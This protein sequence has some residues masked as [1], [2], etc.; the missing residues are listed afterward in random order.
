VLRKIDRYE[1]L[2]ELGHGGMATVYRARDTK[3]D[4]LV[5]LKVMHP[6]LR[7]AKEARDRFR[8][9]AQSVARLAHPRILEIYDYSGEESEESYIAGQLLTGPTLRVWGEA[10][11]PIPAEIVACIGI[12]LAGALAAAHDKGI[13]HR[14]VKP[15]NI[16]LHEA[17]E[18][19]LTD[20]G[21]AAMVDSHSMTA[22]GQILGSPG[23]MAP[24]QI[25]GGESD[26][27]TDLFALGTVLFFLATGRLPFVGKN[28]HQILKRVIDGEHPDPLRLEP[29]MG[30][31]LRAVLERLLATRPADRPPSARALI[32]E[33]RALVLRLGIEDP[34]AEVARFLGAPAEQ[35]KALHAR[36]VERYAVLGKEAK[37]RGDLP[38]AN[39]CFARVLAIDDG[40]PE[41]LALVVEISRAKQ[42]A[43]S[44]GPLIA[45]AAAASLALVA[46]GLR[47]FGEPSE[48]PA[49]REAASPE[50]GSDT[51]TPTRDAGP[52][53]APPPDA[54]PDALAPELPDAS[55]PV[56]ITEAVRRVAV[57]RLPRHVT[58][59]INPVN[60]MVSI[61]GAPPVSTSAILGRGL[62]LAIGRHRIAVQSGTSCCLDETFTV[63]VLPGEGDQHVRLVLRSR[64]ASLLV[65]GPAGL[66]VEVVGRARGG[67]ELFEVPMEARTE[68]LTV[69]ASAPGHEDAEAELRFRAGELTEWT[70]ALRPRAEPPTP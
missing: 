56:V 30:G 44:R 13:V 67:R 2:D 27:R 68:A 15:E 70:A 49:P 47:F 63:E 57:P 52:P 51:P 50:A 24:E 5:A 41:V 28:P 39:D 45:A 14:D 36:V 33:L 43:A 69:R 19:K 6:H 4:R 42:R 29:R 21:I 31:P 12:E 37:A 65:R 9:E 61:D 54:P 8:R 26:A 64:P 23:H 34:A 18:L 17:R 53:D 35:T 59:D 25:E 22:T 3:L 1:V 40:N 11:A 20:F 32:E 66:R 38:E 58:F 48:H 46:L 62:D 16:L 60:A 10:H 7:G 55:G